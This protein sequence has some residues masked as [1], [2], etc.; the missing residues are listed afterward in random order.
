M[1]MWGF[2]RIRTE[3]QGLWMEGG[4]STVLQNGLR[5]PSTRG[6]RGWLCRG[7]HWSGHAIIL[8]SVPE[9][10]VCWVYCKLH[11]QAP[12]APSILAPYGGGAPEVVIIPQFYKQQ[13]DQLIQPP[14]THK[15]RHSHCPPSPIPQKVV[16]QFPAF[17]LVC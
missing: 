9:G 7:G 14:P 16:K 3:R 2:W 6:S 17:W 4:L 15:P 11:N 5:L 10:G 13:M 12:T 1:G 8:R